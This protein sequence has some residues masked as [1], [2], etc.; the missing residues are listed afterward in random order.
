MARDME[1]VYIFIKL[2]Q[3]DLEKGKTTEAIGE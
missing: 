2:V 1:D 3:E